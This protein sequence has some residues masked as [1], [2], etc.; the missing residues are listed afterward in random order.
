[1]RKLFLAICF[2]STTLMSLP[3][4]AASRA[5]SD[6]EAT[7]VKKT[8]NKLEENREIQKAK[9]KTANMSPEDMD[10]YLKERLQKVVVTKLVDDAGLNGDGA[11]SIE[12]SPEALALEEE[13]KKSTFQQIY[14]NAMN[15]LVN[16]NAPRPKAPIYTDLSKAPQA[17][18]AQQ[19]EQSYQS[20]KEAWNKA[21]IQTIDVLLPPNDT[22]TLVP[23]QEHVPYLFS[24]IEILADGLTQFTDTIVVVANGQKLSQGVVRSFPKYLTS[25][26]GERQKIEVNLVGVTINEMPIEYKIVER[27]DYVFLEP[28][29]NDDLAP[30]VYNY[31]FSYLIDNNIFQYDEFDEFYWDLT[32]S[33]W[34]LVIARAGAVVIFPYGSKSL[35]QS[36][37]SGYPGSWSENAVAISQETDNDVGFVS[38]MPLFIGQGLHMIISLPKGAVSS[39]TMTKKFLRFIN[40]RGDVIFSLL[41]LVAIALSYFLSWRYIRKNKSSKISN[42]H[43]DSPILRYL[44]K[45]AID[46]KTFGAFLLDLYRKNVI[47]IEENDGN[48]LLIK[49]TDN[50]KSLSKYECKAVNNL[51]TGNEAVLNVNSYSIL[52][53]KRAL[54][55]VEQSVRNKIKLISLK[56]NSSYMFFSIGMLV[57]VEFFIAAIHQDILYNFLFMFVATLGFGAYVYTLQHRFKSSWKAYLSKALA[58]AAILLELFILCAIVSPLTALVLLIIVYTIIEYSKLYGKRGGLLSSSVSEAQEYQNLLK[59]KASDIGIGRDFVMHQA[60]ILA[61]DVEGSYQENES[62]KNFYK[63]DII[64]D[65]L[66][67]I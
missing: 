55:N 47:D 8:T 1:M 42:L 22:K 6:M 17:N 7:Q 35:G 26:M 40:E 44:A 12:K 37:I 11:V 65:L 38:K 18:Y 9:E 53:I 20:Q 2:I 36:A 10:N 62:I 59:R 32:G 27:G 48:V 56:L 51:F 49:K 19:A 67:K 25:R 28:K 15:R 46:K 63:L 4:F 24:R 13:A 54:N 64:A 41:G 58:L 52:K 23:A 21:D 43:K 3:C 60:A 5:V 14:D 30:G 61:L 45:G 50:L 29:I 31:R 34:N 57:L 33:V 39:V 16:V 66:K